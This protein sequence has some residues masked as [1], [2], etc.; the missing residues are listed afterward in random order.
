MLGDIV[1]Y[2]EDHDHSELG[3]VTMP[4]QALNFDHAG[5]VISANGNAGLTWTNSFSSAA[6]VSIHRPA[7]F[8]GTGDVTL[9][10]L[11][12]RDTAV[13]GNLQFFARGQRLRR[14]RPLPR[15]LEHPQQHHDQRGP[16]RDARS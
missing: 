5:A 3:Q 10:L 4:A 15:H 7:D 14:R 13:A 16:G 9:K 12:V 6:F 1:G 2:F 11:V 8:A